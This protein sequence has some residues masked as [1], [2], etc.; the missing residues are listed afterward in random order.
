MIIFYF[1]LVPTN[2][3]SV[4]NVLKPTPTKVEAKVVNNK[5]DKALGNLKFQFQKYINI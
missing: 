5:T 1:R 3:K 2:N 4:E